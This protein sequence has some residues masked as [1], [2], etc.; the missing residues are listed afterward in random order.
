M[1]SGAS[2]VVATVAGASRVVVASDF[3]SVAVAVGVVGASLVATI[4]IFV[5]VFEAWSTA[6]AVVISVVV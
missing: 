1:A 6:A 5:V 3:G 4:A 2:P